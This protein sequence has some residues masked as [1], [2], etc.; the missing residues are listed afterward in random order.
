MYSERSGRDAERIRWIDRVTA[1]EC[2]R[3][4]EL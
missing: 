3:L 1:E 4:R 2:D